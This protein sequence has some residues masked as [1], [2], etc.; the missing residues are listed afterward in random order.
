MRQALAAQQT[1]IATIDT[2]ASFFLTAGSLIIG[3]SGLPG[4][5][6][7]AVA[8]NHAW[9][10]PALALYLALLIAVI[11]AYRARGLSS[12]ALDPRELTMYLHEQPEFTKRQ[13]VATFA[14]A[15][16][17]NVLPLERKALWLQRA[18][19]FLGM[20]AAYL[21]V[22]TIARSEWSTIHAAADRLL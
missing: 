18:Q 21:V 14:I 19:A 11:Q 15:H 2:K 17:E 20:E 4:A 22:V 13:L 12:I 7:N 3:F 6:S 9:S 1:Q 16:E 10:V 5:A 8:P